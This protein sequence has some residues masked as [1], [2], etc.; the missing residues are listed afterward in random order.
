M[1]LVTLADERPWA[2]RGSS[3]RL[4]LARR[5]QRTLTLTEEPLS[6]VIH[7]TPSPLRSGEAL[8]GQVCEVINGPQ[9]RARLRSCGR[10]AAHR[11][12]RSYPQCNRRPDCVE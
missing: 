4:L 2:D 8:P 12:G 9:A 10:A 11:V 5:G 6:Q 7:R 1:L 3:H